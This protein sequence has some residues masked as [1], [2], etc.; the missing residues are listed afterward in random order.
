MTFFFKF[1]KIEQ[2]SKVG[3]PAKN[4]KTVHL[5]FYDFRI[6]RYKIKI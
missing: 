6:K 1:N 3:G 5:G 2:Y 4:D